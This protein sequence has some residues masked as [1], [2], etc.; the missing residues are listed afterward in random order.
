MNV[1][2]V[3]GVDSLD[4]RMDGLVACAGQAGIAVVD[5]HNSFKSVTA[6]QGL[7]MTDVLREFIQG[8]VD[9]NAPKTKKRRK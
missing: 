9:K 3:F 7:N 8:Y 1:R 5:L 2:V 4:F 6:A